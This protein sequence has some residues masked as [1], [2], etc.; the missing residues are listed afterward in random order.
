MVQYSIVQYSIVQY[1][2][3]QYGTVSVQYNIVITGIW[4]KI[5]IE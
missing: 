1:S 5:G 3:V 2:I 4:I